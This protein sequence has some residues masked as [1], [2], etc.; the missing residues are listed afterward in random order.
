MSL[1]PLLLGAILLAQ[2]TG[3]IDV[4]VVNART[5]Q[6]WPGW[7]VQVT[8]PQGDVQRLTDRSGEAIFLT[9]NGGIARV[10]VLRRGRL[11]AC[12]AVVDVSPGES[13]VVNIHADPARAHQRCNPRDAQ[14]RVRPGVTSDVYDIF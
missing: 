5:G 4:R 3:Q 12:P 13:T 8:T 14:L 7:T 1:A 11:A 2:N 6:P 9:V 10:D